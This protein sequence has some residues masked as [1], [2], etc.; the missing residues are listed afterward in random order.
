MEDCSMSVT[1]VL[2]A[3]DHRIVRQGLRSLLDSQEDIEVIGE[4]SD[5][6]STI[7]LAAELNPDVVVMD[8]SMPGLNGIEATRQLTNH[9][10]GAAP[11]A[12]SPRV[13]AMSMHSDR[14]IAS[15][16][17]NA[18]AKAYLLKDSAFEEVAAAIRTVIADKVFISAKVA[19]AL[20]PALVEKAKGNGHGQ[21]QEYAA[22][23]L[24]DIDSAFRNLTPREREVLQLLSEGKATKEVARALDVSVKTV[25]THRRQLM[26]KLH[27]YSVAELTKYAVREGITTLE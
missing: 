27:L 16:M 12:H 19:E 2:L 8:V 4:A 21:A 5:G 23:D 3:D 24:N 17:L 6:H 22:D 11:T 15:E 20:G 13:V 10:K 26:E 18:G 14:R 7:E 1:K 9:R 25:E